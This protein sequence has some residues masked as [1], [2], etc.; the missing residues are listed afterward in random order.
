MAKKDSVSISIKP[1]NMVRVK[2]TL[3]GVTPLLVNALSD[4]AKG[5][6]TASA[7]GNTKAKTKKILTP[8]EKYKA[9]IHHFDSKTHGFPAAALKK[10]MLSAIRILNESGN[11]AVSQI[12]FKSMVG[13]YPAEGH[14]FL[15]KLRYKKVERSDSWALL[16]KT[17]PIPVSRPC[18]RDWSCDCV[19]EFDADVIQPDA[20]LNLLARAGAQVGIGAWRPESNGNNGIFE[21]AAT[22]VQKTKRVA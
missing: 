19:I 5:D 21:I 20:V 22:K 10:A 12:A 9:A 7:P 6:I 17:V 13:V 18:Y 15:M 14:P 2:V 1:L 4:A 11:D 8:D 3:R 16:K